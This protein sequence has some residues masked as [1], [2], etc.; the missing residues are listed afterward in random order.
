MLPNVRTWECLINLCVHN[1]CLISLSNTHTH[2]HLVH[3]DICVVRSYPWPIQLT[4]WQLRHYIHIY[5]L[6]PPTSTTFLPPRTFN[7]VEP[8]CLPGHYNSDSHLWHVL[9]PLRQLSSALTAA[10]ADTSINFQ[11]PQQTMWPLD[12]GHCHKR[13]AKGFTSKKVPKIKL[14]HVQSTQKNILLTSNQNCLQYNGK[15]VFIIS[16]FIE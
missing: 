16:C 12:T 8:R 3:S 14:Q 6:P 10:S 11:C 1:N 4:G 13:L 15:I 9:W 2:R 7:L 5:I